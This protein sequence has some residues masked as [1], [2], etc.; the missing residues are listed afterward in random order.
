[1][2]ASDAVDQSLADDL[3]QLDYYSA[4]DAVE[5]RVESVQRGDDER[6]AVVTFDPPLGE[7]F[8]REMDVPVDP[9]ME[10]EFTKLLRTTGYAYQNIADI[11]GARLP[12]QYTDDG[13]DIKYDNLPEPG[14]TLLER[15]GSVAEAALVGAVVVGTFIYWPV[16]G[17]VICAG[18][19]LENNDVVGG[20]EVSYGIWDT[21][22]LYVSGLAVWYGVSLVI[23]IVAAALGIQFPV[24]VVVSL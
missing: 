14:P 22:L 15:I 10:T 19:L 11:A 3:E 18:L 7:P 12:A 5:I 20:D 1:M 9:S 16:A 21:P 23:R 6:T 17:L 2:A 13:W 24:E 8:E 4:G